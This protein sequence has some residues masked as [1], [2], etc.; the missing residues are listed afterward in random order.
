MPNDLKKDSYTR[1]ACHGKGDILICW[2]VL[3]QSFKLRICW[4]L[5]SLWAWKIINTLLTLCLFLLLLHLYPPL[6]FSLL[7]PFPSIHH[8]T[9]PP[10][11]PVCTFCFFSLFW[12]TNKWH[13]QR[14]MEHLLLCLFR[15]VHPRHSLIFI[16]SFRLNE[17]FFMFKSY[18]LCHEKERWHTY[19]QKQSENNI[20]RE[21]HNWYQRY[22]QDYIQVIFHRP[23][24]RHGTAQSNVY[25]N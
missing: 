12:S 22:E 18:I 20:Q 11:L 1:K 9:L 25:F 8:F 19:T 4:W 7:L 6:H 21:K 17:K 23:Y 10:F 3:P 24:F 13:L 2:Y 14:H 5:N 15:L 16:I